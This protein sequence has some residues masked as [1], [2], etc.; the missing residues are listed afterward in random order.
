[1]SARVPPQ[2]F[3]VVERQGPPEVRLGLLEPARPEPCDPAI[4]E[5]PAV[6]G[7]G[8]EQQ[9][10]ER[11]PLD[12]V[13]V[14]VILVLL[15]RTDDPAVGAVEAFAPPAVQHRQIDAAVDR[16]LHAAGAGGL[17]RPARRV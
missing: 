3:A 17:E 7:V 12:R 1:M 14:V 4:H 13:L 10:V 9:I 15:T 8:G 11:Q 5:Q 16:R 2:S 6:A